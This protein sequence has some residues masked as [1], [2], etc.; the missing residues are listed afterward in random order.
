MA[1]S[2]CIVSN[3]LY[4]VDKGGIGR[5]MYNFAVA[6]AGRPAPAD[7]HFLLTSRLA[8]SALAIETAYSGLATIHFCTDAPD[9]PGAL[10]ECIRTCGTGDT[11]NELM[12]ESLRCYGGLLEVRQRRGG[13]FDF[14]EFPDFGGWGAATIA[15]KRSGIGFADTLI[16]VRLHSTF[17]LIADHEP[18]M[19]QPS[20]WMAAR[21]DLERQCLRDAD[22]VVAHLDSTARANAEWFR[23]PRD[24]TN[25]VRV[26]MPPILLS[27]AEDSVQNPAQPGHTRRDFLFSSRLQTFKRPDVFVRAAVHFLD[28]AADADSMFR[29]VSYGW[30]SEY[31]DWLKRLVPARWRERVNFLDHVSE[32]ERT[33]L[34]LDSILVIP[35]DYES[36]CLLAFEARLLNVPTILNRRCAAFGEEPRLWRDGKDCLFFDGDFLSLA[37]RM[38]FA[39]SWTPAASPVPAADAPYWESR[40]A[41]SAAVPD[42]RALSLALIVYGHANPYEL[43]SQLRALAALRLAPI[44]AFVSRDALAAASFPEDALFASGVTL[45]VTGWTEPTPTE[46]QSVLA[47]LDAS[48]VAFVPAG[49]RIEPEFWERAT[50]RLAQ[51]PEAAIFTSHIVATE[52]GV[53]KSHRLNYGDCPTVALTSDRIAHRGSV[54]RRD[55]LLALGLRDTAGD[56]WHEDVC[57]RLVEE[58]HRVL[59]APVAFAMQTGSEPLSRIQ[60]SRFFAWHRDRMAQKLGAICRAGS[61]AQHEDSLVEIGHAT[62]LAR[63]SAA[64]DELAACAALAPPSFRFI[65]VVLKNA[66]LDRSAPYRELEIVL[67]GLS[68]GGNSLPWLDIKFAQF[69]DAPQLEFRESG[70]A[71]ALFR[72]WPP[73]TSDQWGPVAVY[74]TGRTP[75]PHG[76]FFE[77]MGDAD[78]QKLKLLLEN[79]PVLLDG[80]H[81]PEGETAEWK[82][83]AALLLRDFGTKRGGSSSGDAADNQ[84]S[85][86]ARMT[87]LRRLHRLAHRSVARVASRVAGRL[88]NLVS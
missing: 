72:G 18:F 24:W 41:G 61:F 31:V 54:F 64:A 42:Q 88:N 63:Q 83:S 13:D 60:G 69:R 73:P 6:N 11:L 19:H 78:S 3:E 81:L 57:V 53:A 59:V 28:N 79:L 23:F 77:S 16:A 29:I 56:R 32:E 34:M 7:L 70:N 10:G 2:V 21:C 17:A 25:K 9:T 86:S 82:L 65:E 46:I 8:Q 74:S 38:Q 84:H 67:R 33:R 58:G 27:K 30:D 48:T 43:A 66:A 49:M 87:G 14:I 15:A 20:A 62:W 26:E 51:V 47:A 35:S 4:P 36:L 55:V 44:H 76:V 52:K 71:R 80:L 45:H 1:S 22:L 40:S 50:M 39:L 85:G 68:I 12:I 75:H 37:E 5:L